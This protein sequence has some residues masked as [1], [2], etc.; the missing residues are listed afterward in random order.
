MIAVAEPV[1]VGISD[2]PLARE[3]R[4]SAVVFVEN[5][6]GIGDVVDSGNRGMLNAKA[7]LQDIHHRCQ[8]IGGARGGGHY[9]LVGIEVVVDPHHYI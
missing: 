8:A 1:L 5:T 3:R 6:L 7:F 9:G 4:R 2:M